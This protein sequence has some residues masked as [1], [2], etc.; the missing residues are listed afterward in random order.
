MNPRVNEDGRGSE[1]LQA[2]LT[3]GGQEGSVGDVHDR[4][5]MEMP[6]A[7]P[8]GK[9]ESVALSLDDPAQ[10]ADATPMA[11]PTGTEPKDSE[12]TVTAT[13]DAADK[14]AN[15]SPPK[16]RAGSTNSTAAA[17]S[18]PPMLEALPMDVDEHEDE[19]GEEERRIKS[20]IISQV[21]LLAENDD[22]DKDSGVSWCM[23]LPIT[24]ISP[25]VE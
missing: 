8:G 13:N 17:D 23:Q 9:L 18:V 24:V 12:V 20:V 7:A 1:S 5:S 21:P 6:A 15:P 10:P 4:G 3:A 11:V 2:A 14:S 16:P 25:E 22:D 19:E